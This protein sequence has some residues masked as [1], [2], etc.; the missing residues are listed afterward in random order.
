LLGIREAKDV[1]LIP[2]ADHALRLAERCDGG[3][4][5]CGRPAAVQAPT[6]VGVRGARTS[7]I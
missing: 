6:V 1:Q 7:M 2:P 4:D 5:E 3:R